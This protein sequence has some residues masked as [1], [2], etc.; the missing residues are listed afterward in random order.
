MPPLLFHFLLLHLFPDY[1]YLYPYLQ[2]NM[3]FTESGMSPDVLINPHAFP[4]RMTIGKKH[5]DP[6]SLSFPPSVI[7]IL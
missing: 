7:F 5:Y 2:E 3:P 4:S 6:L 1:L